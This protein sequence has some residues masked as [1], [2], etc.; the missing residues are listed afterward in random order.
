MSKTH[1]SLVSSG[2]N[3]KHMGLAAEINRPDD[4]PLHT[5]G[6]AEAANEKDMGATSNETFAQRQALEASRRVVAAYNKSLL[7]SG[8]MPRD[9]IARKK[10]SAGD[11]SQVPQ[12]PGSL[13]YLDGKRQAM[14]STKLNVPE[15][16]STPRFHEPPARG[17]NPYA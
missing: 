3:K 15:R 4:T 14:N 7:G 5:S 17:Y 13:S 6:Y 8:H 16:P 1:D 2:Y 12:R 11:Q 9:I 10:A